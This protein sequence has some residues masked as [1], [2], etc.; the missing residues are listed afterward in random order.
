MN[1]HITA[2]GYPCKHPRMCACMYSYALY[3]LFIVEI[4]RADSGVHIQ[5]C[6]HVSKQAGNGYNIPT[7]IHDIVYSTKSYMYFAY[8][9][10]TW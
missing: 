7:M 8:A 1:V 3:T 9:N 2:Q 4:G 5:V 6:R 10:K